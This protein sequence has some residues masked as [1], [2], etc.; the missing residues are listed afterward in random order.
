MEG[1]VIPSPALSSTP[2]HSRELFLS[3]GSPRTHELIY[4]NPLDSSRSHNHPGVRIKT[5]SPILKEETK[6]EPYPSWLLESGTLRPRERL[7]VPFGRVEVFP[8]LTFPYTPSLSTPFWVLQQ[9]LGPFQSGSPFFHC[10]C[11]THKW[12]GALI[13]RGDLQWQRG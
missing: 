8:F 12:G 9:V 5:I 4:F 10:L 1:V 3:R 7:R 6:A 2:L 11:S 13:L